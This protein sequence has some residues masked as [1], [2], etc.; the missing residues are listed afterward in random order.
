MFTWS[1][2]RS[3]A[4]MNSQPP[5]QSFRPG[6]AVVTPSFSNQSTPTFFQPTYALNAHANAYPSSSFQPA[7]SFQPSTTTFQPAPYAATPY[8]P[9]VQPQYASAST[10]TIPSFVSDPQMSVAMN[11]GLNMGSKM[12]E[13]GMDKAQEKVTA[14]CSITSTLFLDPTS[15][16][17]LATSRS[18]DFSST[19]A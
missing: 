2:S 10:A 5:P 16:S 1:S 6:P 7:T 13:E 15:L 11:L 17:S 9:Q 18:A 12:F 3:Q 14:D 8:Q 19:S 4:R